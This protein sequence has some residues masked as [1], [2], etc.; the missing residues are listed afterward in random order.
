VRNANGVCKAPAGYQANESAC[1]GK[2]N[3]CDG[4]VDEGC[5]A[6]NDGTCPS[7]CARGND[8]DCPLDCNDPQ[9]WPSSWV[10]IEDQVLVLTN[11]ERAAGATCGGTYYP[12][13][14]ALTQDIELREAARC[15]SLDMA[16][17]DFFSHTGSDGSNA[18]TRIGRTNY[19]FSYWAENI[20]AGQS[21]AS[22]VVNG[23]MNSTGHCKNIM[24][25]TATELGVGYMFEDP[26]AFN[27]YR[28]YWTQVFGRPR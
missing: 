6:H 16:D 22:N 8:N 21:T 2:D 25:S 7:T 23:W 14:P 24:S 1:D 11:Q 27:N 20:A 5:C 19:Q 9:G 26:D 28:R 13:V 12:S 10:D 18:G 3:N 17:N 4:S 15:H